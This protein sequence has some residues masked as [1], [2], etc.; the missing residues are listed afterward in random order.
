METI[1]PGAAKYHVAAHC[2]GEQQQYWRMHDLLFTRQKE[3]QF[4]QLVELTEA[5]GIDSKSVLRCIESDKYTERVQKS[6]ADG[7]KAMVRATPTLF[8]GP[9]LQ[10]ADQVQALWMIRGAVPY[11]VVRQTIE[12]V[13]S[14]KTPQ[15]SMR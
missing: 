11:P 15:A 14:S 4:D 12:K 1:H 13:L 3:I 8:V 6:L 5:N 2:A 7:R 9:A 10:N